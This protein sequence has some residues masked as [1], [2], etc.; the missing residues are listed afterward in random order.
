M[1]IDLRNFLFHSGFPIDKVIG[2]K[3]GSYFIRNQ[4]ELS[5]T[6][7]IPHGLPGKSLGITVFSN[8]S[9]FRDTYDEGFPVYAANGD[10]G[11]YARVTSTNIEL[12]GWSLD[13]SNRTVYWRTILLESSETA[14]EVPLTASSADTL[15][16]NTAYNYSKL[17]KEGAVTSNTTVNHKLGFIPQAMIWM[18]NGTWIQRMTNVIDFSRAAEFPDNNNLILRP[19]NTGIGGVNKLHYRIYGD[20]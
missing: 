12:L 8:Y 2:I 15:Q 11:L 4:N 3:S 16:F 9:D 5:D 10:Y 20:D 1:A 6:V 18:D 14:M 17:V 13:N 7:Y 19:G